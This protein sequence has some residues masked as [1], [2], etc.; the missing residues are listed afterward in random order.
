[1]LHQNTVIKAHM[2]TCT[3]AWHKNAGSHR[4][5]IVLTPK[6]SSKTG[7]STYLYQEWGTSKS[8][9]L[10]HTLDS[11][12]HHTAYQKISKSTEYCIFLIIWHTHSLSKWC[13]DF[14]DNNSNTM[15]TTVK[16]PAREIV[17]GRIPRV[18]PSMPSRLYICDIATRRDTEWACWYAAMTD[19]ACEIGVAK[20]DVIMPHDNS[21]KNRTSSD[22]MLVSFFS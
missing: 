8:K 14:G 20:E 21:S 17:L 13:S 19:G 6:R 22:L 4:T 18:K 1:M 7:T 15:G 9:I 5:I 16:V 11:S 10:D 2:Y 3:I 12:I